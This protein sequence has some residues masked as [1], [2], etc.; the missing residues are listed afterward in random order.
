MLWLAELMGLMATGVTSIL[1]FGISFE[2]EDTTDPSTGAP[3]EANKTSTISLDLGIPDDPGLILATQDD[4]TL[5][6]SPGNDTIYAEEGN[7][8]ILGSTGHDTLHGE[9]GNDVIDGN[10]N[11]DLVFGHN[12][13]DSLH[14]G[15][16]DD[17]LQGSAGNDTVAGDDGDDAVN[18]GLNN[19]IVSG[20]QGHD[21]VS[22]GHGDDVI[23]GVEDDTTTAH[24]DDTDGGDFLNGGSGDD[25]II[26]GEQ[27]T[28]TA[29]DGADTIV[30]GDWIEAGLATNLTDFNAKDDN[31]LLVYADGDNEP[32]IS[33]QLD[34]ETQGV[35]QIMMNGVVVANVLNGSEVSLDDIAVMP[36]SLAQSSGM[37]PL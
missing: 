23:N 36:L 13:N 32:D 16:G 6:G 1:D 37:A 24:F 9:D 10:D 33:L 5:F 12:G 2:E 19:D 25:V 30:S 21:T 7:D 14:G 4:D 17:Y 27:D 20:G 34:P 29:G 22:G 15:A 26:A 31:V 3:L 18:G 8:T 35:T 11:N 28:V